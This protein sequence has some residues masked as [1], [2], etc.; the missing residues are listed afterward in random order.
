LIIVC[1]IL[2]LLSFSLFE[3]VLITVSFIHLSLGPVVPFCY[4]CLFPPTVSA[5]GKWTSAV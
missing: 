5:L 3:C 1:F 2:P 4:V